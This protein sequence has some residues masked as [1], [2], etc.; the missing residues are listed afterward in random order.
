MNCKSYPWLVLSVTSIGVTLQAIN[1]ST[2]TVAL[3]DVASYFH[4]GAI[5]SSW[6]LLSYMLVNTILILIFGKIADIYGRRRLYLFGLAEFTVVSLLS[7]FAPNVYI[8]IFL[9]ILQAVGG[10]LIITNT[11]PLITDIFPKRHLGTALGINAL[12]VSV[13]RLIGPV[14]GGFLVYYFGWRWV[15]WFNVPIGILGIL[16]AGITLKP[17]KASAQE[18]KV[19]VKGNLT[20]FLALGGLIFAISEG[21]VIGWSNIAVMIGIGL[22]LVFTPWFVWLEH[23]VQFPLIDFS[24]FSK[25]SFTM[26]NVATFLNSIARS[27]VVL[28]IALY[29][30]V[31]KNDNPFNAGLR[32][33]PVTLGM[34]VASPIAGLLC[35]RFKA[36]LLSTSG[37]MISSLGLLLLMW[38][39]D[40]NASDHLISISQLFIGLGCGFFLTPNTRTIMMSVPPNRRGVANGL[41][42]MLQN[43]GQVLSTAV[44]LA[45][46]SSV[47]PERLKDSI[48]EGVATNFQANDLELITNGYKI[49][50][51]VMFLLT[52]LG[53]VVSYL[54]DS[55]KKTKK[56]QENW[57][58]GFGKSV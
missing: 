9:R 7:G 28:L 3:H 54:R 47:L 43:M 30:Q 26:A 14:V 19:D 45:I 2:L 12:I 57:S 44:S 36:K 52:L 21:G 15:F 37:L 4:S 1:N 25:R 18:E 24:L 17:D 41:R 35:A 56:E 11:T 13:S 8:L 16:W 46:V 22:F 39:I 31:V 53:V 32:V 29:Y 48:Y 49:S 27:S 55:D 58:D 40:I 23:K 51:F 38:N 5:A 50:F 6:I 20:L 10:A 33:I 42:S 34:I